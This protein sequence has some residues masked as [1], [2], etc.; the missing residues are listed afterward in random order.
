[1]ILGEEFKALRFGLGWSTTEEIDLDG[2]CV[3][4]RYTAKKDHVFFRDT[5]TLDG[6]VIH[7]GDNRKGGDGVKDD[8]QILVNL[9]KI[10]PKINTLV[11]IVN[12]F[13]EGKSF[14]Q[15]QNA[16]VRLTNDLNGRELCRFTLTNCSTGTAL[17]MAKL[18][19]FG[20]VWKLKALGQPAS[21]HTFDKTLPEILPF[22]DRPAPKRTFDVRVHEAKGLI[23]SQQLNPYFALRYDTC[24]EISRVLKTTSTPKWQQ[25][26]KVKGEDDLLEIAVFNK[27]A[28]V[29]SNKLAVMSKLAS[30]TTG[31]ELIGRL[32]IPLPK[33]SQRISFGPVWQ[34]L[35]K[36]PANPS[37]TNGELC[38][39][40]TQIL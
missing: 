13:D 4:L 17:I 8:E 28:S 6:S 1:V 40:V 11:F 5:K 9:N 26:V 2:S 16:Y 3:L 25:T 30:Q 31:D 7:T 15:V 14:A 39:S 38:I 20:S 36:S 34:P 18:S 37:S 19:R 35:L 12:V 22:L 21:G 10:N 33:D 29:H 27:V 24:R 23:S 32:S